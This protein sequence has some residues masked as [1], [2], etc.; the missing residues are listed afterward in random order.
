MIK[1]FAIQYAFYSLLPYLI[2]LICNMDNII[3]NIL[4]KIPNYLLSL[5]IYTHY[6]SQLHVYQ[7]NN[8][9]NIINSRYKLV[10]S[11]SSKIETVIIGLIYPMFGGIN[12]VLSHIINCI[13]IAEILYSGYDIRRR[14]YLYYS[15]HYNLLRILLYGIPLTLLQYLCN[16]TFILNYLYN[17]LIIVQIEWMM[18][19]RAIYKLHIPTCQNKTI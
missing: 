1:L 17:T 2:L 15:V 8:N 9:I 7:P 12:I 16:N 13:V 14:L 5:V 19:Y 18:T 10:R 3:S 6:I 4:W 11:L